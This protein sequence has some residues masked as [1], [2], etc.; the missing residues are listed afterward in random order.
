MDPN[1]DL[2]QRAAVR[3]RRRRLRIAAAVALP[4]LL[5]GGVLLLSDRFHKAPD[6]Y[7][8]ARAALVEANLHLNE[9]YNYEQDLLTQITNAHRELSTAIRYLQQAED[10]EPKT[11]REIDALQARLTALEDREQTK[12]LT[13]ADLHATYRALTE[14][15]EALV[16]RYQ[17][18]R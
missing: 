18:G 4:V 3:R 12:S 13:P 14:E 10:A 2:P 7:D 8:P 15:I 16:H 6:Y 1:A 5:L 9:A 11:K 17:S